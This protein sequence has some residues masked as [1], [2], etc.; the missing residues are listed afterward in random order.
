MVQSIIVYSLMC[1]VLYFATKSSYVCVYND[2]FGIEQRRSN[3]VGLFFAL[4]V[5]AFFSGVRWDV[6]VDHLAYVRDYNTVRIIGD[7]YRED[8]E[9]GYVHLMRIF[10]SIGAHSTVFFGV[11]AFLQLSFVYYAFKNQKFIFPYLGVLI[12]CGGDFFFWMNGIRQALVATC[13]V[14]LLIHFVVNKRFI[15]YL[16]CILIAS[17]IHKSALLLT[18]FYPLTYL[19]LEKVYLRR[20]MQYF[21]FISA[22]ILSSMNIWTYLLDFVD[23]IFSFIGYDERFKMDRIEDNIR[24]QNFGIR[25]SL[26]LFIDI[27][28]IYYS[29][30]LRLFYLGRNF[31]II[32][33]FYFIFIVTQPLFVS[34]L[35]FSRITGYFYLFRAIVSA[36]LL[37]YLFKVNRTNLNRYIGIIILG[38]Y[39]LHI[40][41]QIYVDKGGHT[42]CIRY[43]FFWDI[44]S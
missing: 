23:S 16:I 41:T 14:C 5:F 22:L 6:G 19:N 12:M 44:S 17:Y 11:V 15:P 21:I 9:E 29:H 13:F 28:I 33:I 4:L 8:M 37:F 42:G 25:K 40:L 39:F 3:I 34:S 24:E 2:G 18:V 36:Y 10:N 38:F 43:Q 27:I 7:V 35:V 1:S 20:D 30:K 31:G 26:F 32:Y